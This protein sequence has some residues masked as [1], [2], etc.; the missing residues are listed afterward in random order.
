[1]PRA[2]AHGF[3]PCA[4][5]MCG[6]RT[7]VVSDKVPVDP[8]VADTLEQVKVAKKRKKALEDGTASAVPHDFG[9]KSTGASGKVGRDSAKENPYAKFNLKTTA[10][11]WFGSCETITLEFATFL[12]NGFIWEARNSD[13]FHAHHGELHRMEELRDRLTWLLKMRG[14]GGQFWPQEDEMAGLALIDFVRL[15]PYMWD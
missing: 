2:D 6:E 14:K 8:A 3:R 15:L 5:P 4:L 7:Q 12:L 9:S 1:M 11:T 10:G 13:R